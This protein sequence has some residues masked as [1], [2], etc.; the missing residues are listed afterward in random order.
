MSFPQL[1]MTQPPMLL[2]HLNLFPELCCI[3][4]VKVGSKPDVLNVSPGAGR[5]GVRA[6]EE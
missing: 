2:G 1:T 6:R 5:C 4:V 3:V